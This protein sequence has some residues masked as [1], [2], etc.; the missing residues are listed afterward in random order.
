MAGETSRVR[1]PNMNPEG[2]RLRTDIRSQG[3]YQA[4]RR[5]LAQLQEPFVHNAEDLSDL[6]KEGAVHRFKYTLELAWKTMKD[7]LEYGGAQ[8]EPITPRNVIKEAFAAKVISNGDIWIEML[9][10][11]NLLSHTYNSEVF[12]KAISAIENQYLPIFNGLNQWLSN[13]ISE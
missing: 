10:F 13:Q 1:Y 7:F 8:I 11:R 12:D 4:F 3:R 2:T 6:G 9:D 5:A